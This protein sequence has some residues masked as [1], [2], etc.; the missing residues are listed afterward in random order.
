[1]LRLAAV[2]AAGMASTATAG[3]IE[4]RFAPPDAS[5]AGQALDHSAW[6]ALLRRYVQPGS[7]GLNRVDYAGFKAGG[8]R[9]LKGYVAE[10]QAA[11]VGRLSRAEQFAF[12]ANLYNARTVDIV[13]DAYPVASIKDIRL[14][15]GLKALVGGGPWQAEVVR[16]AGVGLSLDDIENKILRPLF[17]DPRV[18]Y[19]INCASIG[20]PNLM[21][22]ALTG[23]GLDARLDSAARAYIGSSRGLAIRDGRATASSIYSWFQADFGGSPEAVLA[24]MRRHAPP[25]LAGQL[26]RRTTIDAFDYDWRLND[27]AR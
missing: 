10:L 4:E 2:V 8:H 18:H 24:H 11:D 13:L 17:G 23:A 25:E 5:I 9:A 6:T 21:T 12:W 22:E 26:A 1:M 27:V 15:G 20:C 7:D 19:A 16:V 3:P 14:G